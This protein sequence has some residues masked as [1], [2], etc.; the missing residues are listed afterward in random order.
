VVAVQDADQHRE[1]VDVT[2][3]SR[4]KILFVVAN[5]RTATTTGW[6][7]GFWASELTHPSAQRALV[8]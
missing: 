6:P 5:P 4:P 8:P 2:T 7:V 3:A 1:A